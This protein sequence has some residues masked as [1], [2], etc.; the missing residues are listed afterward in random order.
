MQIKKDTAF[1]PGMKCGRKIN[2]SVIRQGHPHGISVPGRILSSCL[3][4]IWFISC[5]NL[6]K[7]GNSASA[8]PKKDW[9]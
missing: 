7:A 4:V 6:V 5:L 3:D 1:L 2:L 9:L 8:K